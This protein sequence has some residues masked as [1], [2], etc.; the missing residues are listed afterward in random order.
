MNRI[1][2]VGLF[3]TVVVVA[4]WGLLLYWLMQLPAER[5]LQ[6]ALFALFAGVVEYVDIALPEGSSTSAVS[7]IGIASI[8]IF[9]L[10][11]AAASMVIGVSAARLLKER[12]IHIGE[13][14]FVSAETSLVVTL[15]GAVMVGSTYV[16]FGGPVPAPVSLETVRVAAVCVLYFVLEVAIGQ[17]AFSIE[18]STPFWPVLKGALKFLAPIYGA[19]RVG[20]TAA[21]LTVCAIKYYLDVIH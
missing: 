12:K 15:A 16:R 21:I 5:A 11:Q 6:A 13:A 8:L 14:L 9:P 18:E 2:R 19:L 3:Q 17:L 1:S 4:G 10:P 20:L 7:A